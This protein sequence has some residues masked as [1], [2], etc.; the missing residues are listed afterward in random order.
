MGNACG[1]DCDSHA[2]F[3][4]PLPCLH[5]GHFLCFDLCTWLSFLCV[6]VV[7]PYS[8]SLLR[9]SIVGRTSK[10][11]HGTIAIGPFV[12]NV[13]RVSSEWHAHQMCPRGIL[14][15]KK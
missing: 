6:S 13:S 12:S 2:T 8:L 7:E 1:N 15:I 11:G 9:F 4:Y 14:V 5:C 10:D 3:L